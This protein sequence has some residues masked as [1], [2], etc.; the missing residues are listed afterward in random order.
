MISVLR[1]VEIF[2]SLLHWLRTPYPGLEVNLTGLNNHRGSVRICLMNDA[3][4]FLKDCYQ[5]RLYHFNRDEGLRVVFNGVPAGE[6]AI[7]AFHDVDGNGELNCDGLFGLPSEAYAFSNNP[8]TM[9][10]P[11]KYRKCTFP[12]NGDRSIVLKF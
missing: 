5:G 12:V 10:G 6:Y 8:S 11:P 7:M 1:G 3:G 2:Q 9:F 4:Q